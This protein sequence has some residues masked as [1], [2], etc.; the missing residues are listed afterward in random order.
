MA[1]CPDGFWGENCQLDRCE[2][3]PCLNN[4]KCLPGWNDLGQFFYQCK[5]P[6][7]FWGDRCQF[8]KCQAA[9]CLNTGKC[10]Q[11][12]DNLGQV[13][14]ECKCFFGVSLPDRLFL[15]Q[16]VEKL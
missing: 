6:A 1:V 13:V 4:G 2:A 10:L 7:P 11:G 14:Y 8:D 12:R 15:S 3:A 9:P 5:C 16:N